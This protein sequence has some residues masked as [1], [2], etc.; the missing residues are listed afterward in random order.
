MDDRAGSYLFDLEPRLMSRKRMPQH[1]VRPGRDALLQIGGL[2][3]TARDLESRRKFRLR[4]APASK[5]AAC[6]KLL[7]ESVVLIELRTT[8]EERS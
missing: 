1:T 6:C 8:K 2:C 5:S 3:N 7:C 4:C